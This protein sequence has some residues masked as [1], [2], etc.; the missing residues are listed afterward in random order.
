MNGWDVRPTLDRANANRRSLAQAA[1]SFVAGSPLPQALIQCRQRLT[2]E[3]RLC[4]LVILS[5]SAP[6]P[7]ADDSAVAQPTTASSPVSSAPQ[8]GPGTRRHATSR[9]RHHSAHINAC[10]AAWMYAPVWRDLTRPPQVSPSSCS[11]LTLFSRSVPIA[12]HLDRLG[13]DRRHQRDR[14]EDDDQTVQQIRQELQSRTERLR[15]AVMRP[16][17]RPVANPSRPAEPTR[18]RVSRRVKFSPTPKASLMSAPARATTP[19]TATTP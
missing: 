6:Q 5:W 15:R 8:N 18:T 9:A 13:R 7:V 2:D 12:Q 10:R 3:L 14:Q 4:T 1:G 19:R 11:K 17:R 16:G